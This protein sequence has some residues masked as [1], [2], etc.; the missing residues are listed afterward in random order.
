MMR[1][2]TLLGTPSIPLLALFLDLLM[3]RRLFPP[4]DR[5]ILLAFTAAVALIL[6]SS[7]LGY[8]PIDVYRFGFSPWAPVVFS[9][10]AIA[11]AFRSLPLACTALAALVAYDVPLFR[12][13]NLFD[14]VVDPIIGIVAIVWLTAVLLRAIARPR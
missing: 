9:L 8:V 2:V 14:Y 1:I 10:L 12:S 6:Y 3:R 5:R 13:V 7:T 4:R 11:A